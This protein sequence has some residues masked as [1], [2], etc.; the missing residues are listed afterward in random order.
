M[1]LFTF[2]V[3]TL[4]KGGPNWL[5]WEP[6]LF[7]E[8]EEILGVSALQRQIGMPARLPSPNNHQTWVIVYFQGP[9]EFFSSL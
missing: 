3:Y 5:K 6:K 9:E 1:R 4:F 7:C 8:N 2:L